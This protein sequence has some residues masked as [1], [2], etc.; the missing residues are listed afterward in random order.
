MIALLGNLAR[1][2]FPGGA[3]RVGGGPFHAARALAELGV[4]AAVYARCAAEDRD[5]LLPAVAALAPGVRYVPGEATASFAIAEDGGG[6]RMEVLSLGDTWLPSDL[7]ALPAGVGWIHV[8]AL[9]RSDFPPASL[10][11]LAAGRRLSLDGQ[12]LVRP[13]RVG[14]LVLDADYDPELLRAVWVLKLNEEEAAVLGDPA[15]LGVPELVV[16]RGARG[17]TVYADGRV[18]EIPARAVGDN[19]TGTGDQ[20]AVAYLDGRAG[21]LDPA[22]AARRATAV[23]AALLPAGA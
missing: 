13:A 18:E 1:D 22:S 15:R 14:E 7:P 9:L 12:G 11:A 21:G 8:A 20:F 19:H 10:A 3:P 17:A 6:R 4:E 23:V 16:T 5:D 2:V